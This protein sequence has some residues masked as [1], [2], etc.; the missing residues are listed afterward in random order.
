MTPLGT[1][2]ARSSLTLA[3]A[4]SR[5]IRAFWMTLTLASPSVL[6]DWR[7]CHIWLLSPPGSTNPGTFMASARIW[8]SCESV[9]PLVT[10]VMVSVRNPGNSLSK[11]S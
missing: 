1:D 5:L 11:S 3:P 9:A 2:I 6:T 10:M 4:V 8:L 7:R